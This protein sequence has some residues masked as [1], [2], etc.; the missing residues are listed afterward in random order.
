MNTK[1]VSSILVAIFSIAAIVCIIIG[2]FNLAVL[3]MT[4]MFALSN[5]FRAKSFKEQGYVKEA[6]WM[7]YMAIFFSIASIAVLIIIF[8]E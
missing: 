5:G 6:K 4:I 2:N 3:A 7:K 8:T 1:W